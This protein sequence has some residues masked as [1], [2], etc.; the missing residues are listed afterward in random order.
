MG[1]KRLRPRAMTLADF[2]DIHTHGRRGPSMI[3]NIGP[4]DTVDTAYGE[5]WYSVG[6]HPWDTENLTPGIFDRLRL[7]ASDPRV[8]AIGEAASTHKREQGK[9][10]KKK[11]SSNRPP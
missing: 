5:A 2:D 6:I 11:S 9:N 4:D 10:Y 3:T 8:V 7:L 1:R